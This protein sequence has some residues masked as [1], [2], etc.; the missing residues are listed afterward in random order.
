MIATEHYD[1]VE[2]MLKQGMTAREIIDAFGSPSDKWQAAGILSMQPDLRHWRRYRAGNRSL[3]T[4]CVVMALAGLVGLVDAY[5]ESE[6]W[7]PW[8]LSI[9]GDLGLVYGFVRRRLWAYAGF[10]VWLLW[11]LLSDLG[12]LRIPGQ[13]PEPGSDVTVVIFYVVAAV[14][15]LIAYRIRRRLYPYAGMSGPRRDKNGQLAILAD[16]E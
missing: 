6:I 16:L 5:A 15:V 12:F 11:G 7:T 9:A 14:L 2:D 1:K 10:P 3:I 8:V 13:E 4:F